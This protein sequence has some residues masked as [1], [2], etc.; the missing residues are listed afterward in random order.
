MLIHTH[1][2]FPGRCH[3]YRLIGYETV[4][5]LGYENKK[6]YCSFPEP[7]SKEYQKNDSYFTSSSI[8]QPKPWVSPLEKDER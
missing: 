6:H 2:P 3:N 1:D 5:C 4:R 7:P 8:A